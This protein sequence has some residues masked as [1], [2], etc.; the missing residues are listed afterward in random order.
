MRTRNNSIVAVAKVLLIAL[1]AAMTIAVAAPGASAASDGSCGGGEVCLYRN[2]N[3]TG[4]IYDTAGS[5]STY[6]T[7]D[8]FSCSFDC[9]VNDEVSSFKNNGFSCEVTLYKNAS[10]GGPNTTL[11]LGQWTNMTGTPIG[12]DEASS[13]LWC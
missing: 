13:H 11:D 6:N 12:N 2:S 1:F 8:F 10:Y 4:Q 3:L 7:V 5:I 9:S